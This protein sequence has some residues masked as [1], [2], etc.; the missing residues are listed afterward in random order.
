MEINVITVASY[1][2]PH[3]QCELYIPA[4]VKT[5]LSILRH[6]FVSVRMIKVS[7]T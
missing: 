4:E 2:F 7:F 6:S 5:R 3:N 1:R